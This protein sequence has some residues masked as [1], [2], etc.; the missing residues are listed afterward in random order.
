MIR[1]IIWPFDSSFITYLS[2][3]STSQWSVDKPY[4]HKVTVIA[5]FILAQRIAKS[6]TFSNA[7]SKLVQQRVKEDI[8][9]RR[10]TENF[11]PEDEAEV[12][13]P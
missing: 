6:P 1:D 9:C 12:P 8:R 2:F 10:G 3:D 7:I 5:L 4:E 13:S 11:P